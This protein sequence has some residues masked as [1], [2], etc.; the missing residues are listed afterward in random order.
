[1][2]MATRATK[3]SR[4]VRIAQAQKRVAKGK[5]V[6]KPSPVRKV[7]RKR[8]DRRPSNILPPVCI[9][10][11]KEKWMKREG[12]GTRPLE[13]L[14]QGGSEG[15]MFI[16]AAALLHREDI[17]RVLNYKG[18]LADEANA[19]YSYPTVLVVSPDTD[20]FVLAIA[21]AHRFDC[22]LM[23]QVLP[24]QLQILAQ[25]GPQVRKLKN[26]EA[27]VCALYGSKSDTDVNSLRHHL[28]LS[29]QTH[30][31]NTLP[32]N[33]DSFNLHAMCTAYQTGIHRRCLNQYI[34]A[35]PQS[36]GWMLDDNGFLVFKWMSLPAVPPL[37]S[38]FVQ[39]VRD[40]P[41]ANVRS[42]AQA[43]ACVN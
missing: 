34:C 37:V 16:E 36:H 23:L 21:M 26:L 39:D 28:F 35:P 33:Q 42:L 41:A 8:E 29:A 27:F 10:C 18:D 25:S 2:G 43:C 20:V 40:V 38:E 13:T 3:L 4:I 7:L 31:D 12:T 22:S 5:L 9:I 30:G 15:H 11:R 14:V 6:R 17:F 24:R 32:P 1:M 19:G